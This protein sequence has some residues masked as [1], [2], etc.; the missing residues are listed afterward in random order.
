MLLSEIA[1]IKIQAEFHYVDPRFITAIRVAENGLG[2]TF[3]G[4]PYGVL[5]DPNNV[6]KSLQV[7]CA[8]IRDL[9]LAIQ[10][11]KVSIFS[12]SES[13]GNYIS[14]VY[15]NEAIKAIAAHWA[16]IGADN[17]PNNKN[18]NWISNVTNWYQKIITQGYNVVI[19]T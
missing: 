7:A 5:P 9:I 8:S 16:P 2:D 3:A 14:L 4:A 1:T 17:D 13:Y 11:A 18:A 15:S 19:T 6:A 12:H 10:T